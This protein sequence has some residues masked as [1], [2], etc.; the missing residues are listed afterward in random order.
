MVSL[1]VTDVQGEGRARWRA[2]FRALGAGVDMNG[3][4][5]VNRYSVV[6]PELLWDPCRLGT[7]AYHLPPRRS[8]AQG[9]TGISY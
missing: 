9:D 8:T 6:H 5:G 7:V 1:G 3:H 2:C 4:L